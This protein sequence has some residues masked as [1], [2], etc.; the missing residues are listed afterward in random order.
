MGYFVRHCQRKDLL[1]K[2]IKLEVENALFVA[3][4]DS[5][6]CDPIVVWS[7]KRPCCFKSLATIFHLPGVHYFANGQAL[8]TTKIMQE[9][10][11][12][13][14]KKMIAEGRKVL[15]FLDNAP[16]H[17]NIPQKG[18]KNIKLG[19]IPKYITSRLH[20]CSAGIIKNFKLKSKRLF[21]C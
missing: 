18:L 13:L 6:D 1:K 21:I 2:E 15:F 12:M 5:K 17:P 14:D 10:L 20:P 9:I 4:Y 19:L 16:S 3:A 8:I 7:S 11:R